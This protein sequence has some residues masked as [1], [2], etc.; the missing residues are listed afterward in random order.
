MT[1]NSTAVMAYIG[2]GSNLDEP[3]QQITVAVQALTS[4]PASQFIQV[5]SL[6]LTKALLPEARPEPQ[7]DY[8]NAVVELQTE[9]QPAALLAN[10]QAIEQRQQ[11]QH[12][13]RW[14]P[15]NIDLDI[16]LYGEHVIKQP[17]LIIPHPGLHKRAF[18]LYPL[19]E[20]A[21]ELQIPGQGPLNALYRDC[22]AH[23]AAGEIEKLSNIVL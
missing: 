23:C 9:L 13:Y 22:S 12:D 14:G 11:R 2:L 19:H 18:V 8:V 15:R 7:P 6:Y 3:Q 10:L 4:L 16:L 20:I 21:P 17:D 1:E 5:S